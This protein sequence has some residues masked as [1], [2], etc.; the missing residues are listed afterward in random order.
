[1]NDQASQKLGEIVT[2]YGRGIADDPRR[3]RRA[4]RPVPRPHPRS[5]RAGQRDRMRRGPR[6]DG[7]GGEPWELLRGRLTRGLIEQTA[8]AE[9]A[10]RW[11]V[12][13]WGLALG[14]ARAQQTPPAPVPPPASPPQPGKSPPPVSSPDRGAD[15]PVRPARNE[16]PR[17][18]LLVSILLPVVF[19][20]L[21]LGILLVIFRP[22]SGRKKPPEEVVQT[23][24]DTRWPCCR[25]NAGIWSVSTQPGCGTAWETFPSIRP[26]RCSNP[27]RRPET[28][29][30]FEK[31]F[32]L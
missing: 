17:T 12:E 19:T 14:V 13:A 7:S 3:L 18:S 1:M 32:R 8:V 5:L 23:S 26:W 6:A 31:W 22:F 9:D 10:A 16:L 27:R 4:G 29:P 21:V 24:F 11:A 15:V 25:A 28:S 2:K 20:G 30:A